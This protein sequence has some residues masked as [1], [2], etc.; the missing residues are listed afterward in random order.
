MKFQIHPKKY[1]DQLYDQLLSDIEKTK[2]ALDIAYS[3]F[4][5]VTDPELIDAYIYELNS[6]QTRYQFLLKEASEHLDEK[7]S[8]TTFATEI[9][10]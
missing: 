7:S 3:G 8:I 10:C 4:D 1:S 2:F 5:N 9:L 6:I